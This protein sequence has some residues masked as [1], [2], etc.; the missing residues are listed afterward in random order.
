[1]DFVHLHVHSHYSILDGAASIEG[2]VAK[3][4]E[5]KMKALALTDHGYMFGI[6]AFFD[7]CKK[8]S[9][10]P[11]L[12][13]EAYL[14]EKG[15]K[16]KAG[17][18]EYSGY[19][20]ILIAKNKIGYHNLVKLCTIASTEGFYQR[21]RIDRELLEKY[22]EGLIVSSACLG[23]EIP[24][25]ILLN[26][27]DAAEKAIEWYKNLF[28]SD[29]YLELMLH[30]SDDPEKNKSVYAE[31]L[32]VNKYLVDAAK[33]HRIKLIAT[34]DIH[35][36]NK[37]DADAHDLLICLTTGKS[38]DD[39][40]RMRYTKQE[41]FKSPDEMYE[42]FGDNLEALTNTCE[43]ADKVEYF[44]L[45]SKPIMPYFK[46][47]ESF[48]TLTE[49]E[50]KFR[51]HDLILDFGQEKYNK[52]DGSFTD[53]LRIKLESDYLEQLTMAG[54]VQK[55]GDPL[56]DEVLERIRFE[57]DTIKTMG[58]PGYFLIVQDF[59]KYAKDHGVI[60]G[61]G[62]GSAA[63]SIIAYC[64]GIIDIDPLK[65]D[66]LF[67]RFLNPDRISMPDVDIDFD[68]DG[69]Q[70][71]L[72]Y[73]TEKYGKENVAHIVTFGT[74]AAKMVIKDV[75]R[76][77][78]LPLSD[79]ERLSGLLPDLGAK[80]ANAYEIILSGESRLG[81][82]EKVI[83]E[84]NKEI[85]SAKKEGNDSILLVLETRK[86]I[87]SEIIDARAKKDSKRLQTL[88]FACTLE[89]SVRQ[90]AVHACGVIIGR[91]ELQNHIPL[92]PSKESSV[93]C[94]QYDG[95][96]VE[97]IGLLKMDFLGLKTLSILR[98]AIQNVKEYKAISIDIHNIPFD[99]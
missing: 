71:V 34:N 60:V 39:P 14:A 41:Y 80:L 66:L 15:H 81:S 46:I 55:Y 93:L 3:A 77:L 32:I 26:D 73:V 87:A 97:S 27:F 7:E 13:V 83:E 10:K 5:Y 84:T 86:I 31:Q 72:N 85:T 51:E 24:Q 74:M 69:R 92:M 22:G 96:F 33:R 62:R 37:A 67:E 56:P 29:F 94:T 35:F 78:G 28:G 17:K 25:K 82:I 57:I 47:P 30:F 54:A 79:A 9:I 65:H 43:I 8:K 36:I 19:H 63:G 95:H 99:D 21:P 88:Q 98:E 12:G 16:S 61:P 52:L 64:N 70:S 40:N 75:A 6:K 68:D 45:N 1:M 18:E 20:V 91:D 2:L 11:L 59:V 4:A 53:K 23:G 89:G 48:A 76:V 44:D 50:K 42:L 49:Y 38:I 90:T 58:F